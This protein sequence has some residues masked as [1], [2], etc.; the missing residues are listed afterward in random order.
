M[1]SQVRDG[2]DQNAARK[3]EFSSP[4]GS[5]EQ[6]SLPAA[7]RSPVP[8]GQEPSCSS[9]CLGT[10]ALRPHAGPRPTPTTAR[11]W[12]PQHAGHHGCDSRGTLPT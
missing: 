2:S 3:G 1:R 10:I 6:K 11:L 4:S 5:S 8:G 7:S 9:R 12:A